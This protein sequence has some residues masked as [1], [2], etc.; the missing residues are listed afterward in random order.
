VW[1]GLP[2]GAKRLGASQAWRGS[3]AES[4][5]EIGIGVAVETLDDW[6][7]FDRDFGGDFD[8]GP[9][10]DFDFDGRDPAV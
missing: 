9:D 10:P 2:E 5:L 6:L 7:G 1:T 8:P 4:A 3:A